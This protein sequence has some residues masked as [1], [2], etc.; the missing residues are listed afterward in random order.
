MKTLLCTYLHLSLDTSSTWD[1]AKLYPFAS[2]HLSRGQN[3]MG[4]QSLSFR[5]QR[6]ICVSPEILRC[7][8]NDRHGRL[9]WQKNLPVQA[10]SIGPYLLPGWDIIYQACQTR[11]DYLHYIC[12]ERQNKSNGSCTNISC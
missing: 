12:M 10:R 6:R 3:R 8:Q 2:F 5:A 9:A 11:T 7:A 4:L 1:N